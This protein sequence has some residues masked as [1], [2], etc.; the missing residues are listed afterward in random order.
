MGSEMLALSVLVIVVASAIGVY[1]HGAWNLVDEAVCGVIVTV[2]WCIAVLYG[3]EKQ[4]LQGVTVGVC[5]TTLAIIAA[6]FLEPWST[7]EVVV[8]IGL[9]LASVGI[10]LYCQAL[11]PKPRGV[12]GPGRS[13][14][15]SALE[16]SGKRNS[17]GVGLER[18]SR[19]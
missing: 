9:A 7:P 4:T 16:L 3:E 8:V 5:A 13:S 11:E 1:L 17:C 18:R 2:S 14:A 19:G 6:A 15:T 12:V 10:V